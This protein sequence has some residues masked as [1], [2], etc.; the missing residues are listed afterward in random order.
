MSDT[1]SSIDSLSDIFGE[2]IHSYTRAQAIDDGVLVDVS[3]MARE[4]GF[5]FPVAVT[6]QLYA[7][8]ITPDPRSAEEGQSIEGRLWDALHMLHMAI[9]G[10]LPTKTIQG[11]GPGQTTLYQ[12]YFIMKRRQR[13]L[14]TLKA[15][16]GPSDNM[17]PTITLMGQHE[18]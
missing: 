4:A 8:V 10:V 11:P 18:D 5:K 6:Q 3:E 2:V 14:L 1:N 7:E 15:V 16:C 17:E 13:K 12:C 9:K